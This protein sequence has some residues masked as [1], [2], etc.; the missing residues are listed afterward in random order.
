MI[1]AAS[2]AALLTILP[3]RAIAQSPTAICSR[4]GQKIIFKGKNF[5]C[6]KSKG[7]L[8][9]QALVPAKPT[10]LLHPTP[11][12]SPSISNSLPP[13][14]T[15]TPTP[16]PPSSPTP[17]ATPSKVSGFLVAQL[18]QLTEG[19]V[20]IVMAKDLQG[21][22]IGLALFLSGTV[23]TAHSVICTHMGCQVGEAGKRL[24]CPC[25]GSVFDGA[26]G[27]VI[28][29]PAAAPLPAYKVAQVSGDIYILSTL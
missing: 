11:T 5:I 20:K 19:Q 12:P 13:T 22:S 17:S 10:I 25:H 8:I 4:V 6:V 27:A 21:N 1:F 9:W 7:K 3:F 24:A 14:P 15:P 29:G 16:K 18:S 26:S 28:N 23:V 2:G